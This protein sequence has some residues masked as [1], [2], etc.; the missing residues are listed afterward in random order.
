M[1]EKKVLTYEELMSLFTEI[2]KK[3][4][5]N[6]KGMAE[7]RELQK[8]TDEQMKK[9]DAKLD[10][11]AKA[12]GGISDNIGNHAEQHF[13]NVFDEKLSFGEQKY[14]E[15]IRNMKPKNKKTANLILFWSTERL[16]R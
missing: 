11:L 10:R 16:L 12:V 1:E 6:T 5:E 15:L 2:G 3:M 7:L 9:T 4:A 8:K 13:Q 14:D